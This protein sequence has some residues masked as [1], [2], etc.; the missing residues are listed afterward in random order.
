MKKDLICKCFS[1]FLNHCL[2]LYNNFYF[3][4]VMDNTIDTLNYTQVHKGFQIIYIDD[5]TL[6]VSWLR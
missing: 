3:F 6:L 5:K 2:D 1:F 4:P